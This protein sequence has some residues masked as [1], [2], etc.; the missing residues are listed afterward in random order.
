MGVKKVVFVY[1][2]F[3]SF[4]L[5]FLII[6]MIWIKDGRPQRNMVAAP[7]CP[8]SEGQTRDHGRLKG[9]VYNVP[10]YLVRIYVT[11]KFVGFCAIPTTGMVGSDYV[12][13]VVHNSTQTPAMQS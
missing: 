9:H 10:T 1:E 11:M 5:R 13:S 3:Y 8:L 12:G 4:F 7:S 2:F 6:I